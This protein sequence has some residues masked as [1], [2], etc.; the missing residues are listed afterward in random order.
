MRTV[1]DEDDHVNDGPEFGLRAML[2]LIWLLRWL[3]GMGGD[4]RRWWQQRPWR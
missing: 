2:D 3:V 1:D 4:V